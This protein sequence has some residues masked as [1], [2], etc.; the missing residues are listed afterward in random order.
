MKKTLLSLLIV[1]IFLLTLGYALPI[2][3]AMVSYENSSFTEENT[4]L[5]C[6]VLENLHFDY[7]SRYD[8]NAFMLKPLAHL[9]LSSQLRNIRLIEA[10]SLQAEVQSMKDLYT[11]DI[12][13]LDRDA[14]RQANSKIFDAPV[15]EDNDWS[16]S[17]HIS[18]SLTEDEIFDIVLSAIATKRQILQDKYPKQYASCS[19]IV[20]ENTAASSLSNEEWD[21][22]KLGIKAWGKYYKNRM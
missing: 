8:W 14:Y 21:C 9:C 1:F 19:A 20:A 5:S 6:N 7:A 16:Y 15:Y 11:L 17:V 4:S 10:E 2:S 12:D 18:S 3:P 13:N 22:L